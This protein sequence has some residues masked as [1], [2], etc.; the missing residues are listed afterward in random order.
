[1]N[2]R[3]RNLAPPLIGLI[4][5]ATMA[6]CDRGQP[7][8]INTGSGSASSKVAPAIYSVSGNITALTA[9]GLTL[10]ASGN[11]VAVP[12]G[13][14]TFQLPNLFAAGA[15]YQVRV[16]AQPQG[17][18]CSVAAGA[19]TIGSASITTVQV[20]CSV[21]SYSVG[22]TITGLDA[23]GLVLDDGTDSV[24]I[25]I[26][27]STFTFPS[28]IASGAAYAVTIQV[29]PTGPACQ[30]INATGTVAA[31]SITTVMVVCGQ[32]AW[33]SGAS[34]TGAAGVYGTQGM[35]AAANMPGARAAAAAWHDAVGGGL[36]LF[37]GDN[38]QGDLNDLWVYLSA[39]GQ[40]TWV[41]GADTSGAHGVYGT[42][43][44]AA[45]GNAPGAR[46]SAAS[47]TNSGGT[48]GNLWLFGG[49]GYDSVGARGPLNDLWEYDIGTGQWA[50]I[51]GA[52]TAGAAAV[53]GTQDVP[54]AA[55]TPGARSGAVSWIDTSG[56]L[57]LF[58]GAGGGGL[59]SDLWEFIPGSGAGSGWAFVSGSQTDNANGVYG[60]LGTA[61]AANAPGARSQAVA[62][63][64]TTGKLWL[65]G[66]AGYGS[67]GGAGLLNDLWVFDPASKQ[68]TWISGSQTVNSAGVYGTQTA[69]AGTPKV[70]GGRD[71]A[72][73]ATDAAGNL[74]L[75][76]GT[77]YDG[78][79]ANG[80]LNDLWQY[81]LAAAQWI[82]MSGS[83][84]IGAIGS[85]GSQGVAAPGNTPG[86]RTAPAA[87][88]DGSG[89]F[90][91]F[92]GQGA[93]ASKS[94]GMLNDLWEFAP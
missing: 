28:K 77:G 79:R 4:A 17:Q 36:W 78:A 10:G 87:W 39:T 31:S 43:G 85:Y 89:D 52:D 35:A 38:A 59:L 6:G 54:D 64:D 46:E 3:V 53:Y 82:W 11:A 15:A 60:T 8:N 23:G 13:A 48:A 75:F 2:G 56:D 18:T 71:G 32:W 76:G 61:A 34:T 1:M 21:N 29:Q 51:S 83:Q 81:N 5:A 72:S 57:W 37:G 20:T 30:L 84:R 90:W 93:A 70:P 67:I 49:T 94:T 25:P 7:A 92:G 33:Q 44:T 69:S 74:W 12:A 73:A 26:G 16:L 65:F 42:Q 40:W 88:M 62:W 24:T 19:G 27:T 91:L 55:N 68:W 14:T 9:G 80:A 86:E 50:W 22:G 58:G 41:S 47:W 45:A 63:L 66:G